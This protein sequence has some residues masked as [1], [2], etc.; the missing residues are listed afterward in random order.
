MLKFWADCPEPEHYPLSY[1][2]RISTNGGIVNL[3]YM[4]KKITPD[5]MK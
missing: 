4:I 3:E 5:A 2:G 1:D